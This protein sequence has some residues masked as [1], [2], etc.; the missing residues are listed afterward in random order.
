[1]SVKVVIKRSG[2][3]QSFDV[4]KIKKVIAW[5]IQGTSLNPLELEQSIHGSF[6]DEESTSDIQKKLI[7][8]A[9][10]LVDIKDNSTLEWNL[11][12]GRLKLMDLYKESA[13]NRGHTFIG[14][15]PMFEDFVQDMV[16]KGLYD[17][18]LVDDYSV[19]EL[20]EAGKFINPLYDM[21]YSLTAITGL[22]GKTLVKYKGRTWELIQER[23]LVCALMLNINEDKNTRMA[24]VRE[25]YEAI[26]TRKISLATPMYSGLGLHNSNLASCFIQVM[27]DSLDSIQYN[28]AVY[29]RISKNGG[30]AGQMWH[31]VRALGAPVVGYP[32]ASGGV[33]PWIKISNDKCVAI[34]QTGQRQG[35]VTPALPIYHRDII[36]FL[37][38]QEEAGDIRRKAYDVSPQVTIPDEF[39]RRALNDE[40]WYVFDPY[41]LRTVLNIELDQVY[42]SEFD[43]AYAL[44]IEAFKSGQIFN[45]VEYRAM[46]LFEKII[47]NWHSTGYPYVF[48]SDTVNASNPNDHVAP[49]LGGN[50]CMESYS[51]M[52][53]STDFKW[54]YDEASN[55]AIYTHNVGLTHIC[56]LM[57]INIYNAYEHLEHIVPLITRILDNTIELTRQTNPESERH[58]D[59]L[60]VIGIGVL[61]LADLMAKSHVAYNNEAAATDFLN[62]LFAEISGRAYRASAELAHEK[63]KYPYYENSQFEKG[64]FLGRKIDDI[65]AE[66]SGNETLRNIW[67][68][69]RQLTAQHGLRNGSLLAIAPTTSTSLTQEVTAGVTPV[70]SKAFKD[71]NSITTSTVVAPEIMHGNWMYYIEQK[72]INQALLYKL[73]SVMQRW[74][75]QGISYEL[76]WDQN[77]EVSAQD[78]ADLFITAWRS[79]CKTI[80]YH[81]HITK[82]AEKSIEDLCVGCAG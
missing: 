64:Y 33:A 24:R 75:D 30:A 68:D 52:E 1:M 20:V 36:E 10:Q 31:R 9:N 43:A 25:T 12:A 14:Y 22:V 5:A 13:R 80:Y 21:S 57:S 77:K 18:R 56:N 82:D 50:L 67:D 46:G 15:N 47:I 78:Y 40:P 66:V 3:A 34:N 29:G 17:G 76:N 69:V 70:Y 63:G 16:D 27:D 7:V 28:E 73:V 11:V 81:R 8:A 62:T 45:V 54:V 71:K 72:N 32:N 59:N 51:P 6:H 48:F 60:R 58:N 19:A 55:T 26:A 79:K 74:V 4:S 35:A 53:P 65:I 61:G 44:A 39:M 49:I 38:I 41:E 37:D 2:V 42:G 23:N